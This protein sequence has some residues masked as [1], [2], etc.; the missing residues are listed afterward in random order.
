MK[1]TI[2][3]LVKTLIHVHVICSTNHGVINPFNR[4]RLVNWV[5]IQ[6]RGFFVVAAIHLYYIYV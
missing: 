1:E 3:T 4:L 5:A 6:G 2:K